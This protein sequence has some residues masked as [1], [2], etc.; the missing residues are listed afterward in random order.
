MK[1]TAAN[2]GWFLAGLVSGIAG[3]VAYRVSPL[4]GVFYIELGIVA[5]VI[6][7]VVSGSLDTYKSVFLKKGRRK[8]K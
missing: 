2:M 8:R 5:I 4:Q 3:G 6:S 7:I 1:F